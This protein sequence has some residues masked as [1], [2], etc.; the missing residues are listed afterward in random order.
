MGNDRSLKNRLRSSTC[1]E[2]SIEC[3]LSLLSTQVL[4]VAS[5]SESLVSRLCE[6]A[7]LTQPG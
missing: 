2:C 5:I 3:F 4:H 7:L 6:S 1:A